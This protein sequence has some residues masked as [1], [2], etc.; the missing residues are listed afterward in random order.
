M[1]LNSDYWSARY[2]EGSTGWDLGGISP[3]LKAYIDQLDESWKQ[4][5]ILIPGCGR[6]YEAEYLYKLGYQEVYLLD[7]A[8]QPLEDFLVRNPNFPK[9][10]LIQSDFFAFEGQFD[11]ILEQTMFCAISPLDREKYISKI[12]SLLTENGK[13][14]GLLF[15]RDF[16]GGPPFG[17]NLEEYSLLFKR[18]LNIILMEPCHN[19]ISPRLGSELFFIAGGVG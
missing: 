3:P 2:E 18:H 14:V 17:G 5:K 4:R 10:Q 6:A 1:E 11:L 19:S 12:A 7:F 9:E 15:N 13:F 16:E 8:S